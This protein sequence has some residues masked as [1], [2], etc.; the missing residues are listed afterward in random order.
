VNLE[1]FRQKK[2][3]FN[4]NQVVKRAEYLKVM[5]SNR[6]PIITTGKELPLFPWHSFLKT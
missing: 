6:V 4:S 3:A 5:N 1:Q 2:T